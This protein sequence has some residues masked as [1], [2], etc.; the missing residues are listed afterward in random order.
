MLTPCSN[1]FTCVL[2]LF[3]PIIF[4][5]LILDAL[6]IFLLFVCPLHGFFSQGNEGALW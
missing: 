5:A 6:K 3:L 2:V 1:V 4:G